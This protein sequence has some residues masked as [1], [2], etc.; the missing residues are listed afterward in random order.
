MSFKRASSL[1]V[2][3]L[4]IFT[5]AAGPV[6]A[7]PKSKP[8]GAT[9]KGPSSRASASKPATSKPATAKPTTPGKPVTH[10]SSS[11]KPSKPPKSGT[12]ATTHTTVREKGKGH[13]TS[14]NSA[15]TTT[16]TATTTTAATWTPTN[17]V[18]E[19][20][21]TKP[22]QLSRARAVLPAG[23]DLNLATAGFK[24]FGQFNAAVN[25][26]QHLGIS[27]ADL[28]A[29]MTGTTLAGLPTNQPV[30]SLGQ[31]IQKFKPG[32]NAETEADRAL[33]QANTEAA[34]TTTTQPR[35]GKSR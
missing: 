24:N 14:T 33:T 21:M 18:S 20:L 1:L 27:F 3:G 28:K 17:S 19:K 5:L 12:T 4:A 11:T 29:A 6:T 31:A 32:V 8:A 2:S 25:V 9:R 10:G 13:S 23:T 22:N 7:A 15:T 30:L 34:T 16:T 26:S 35:H